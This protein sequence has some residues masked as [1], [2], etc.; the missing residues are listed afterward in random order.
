MRET[1]QLQRLMAEGSRAQAEDI[2]IESIKGV[3]V[4]SHPFEQ[5]LAGKKGGSMALANVVPSDRFFAWFAEPK[6][7]S[8][9]LTGGSDFIFYG[10]ASLSGTSSEYQ[11][12]ER[13]LKKLGVDAQWVRGFLESGV[14]SELAVILPDLFLLEGTDLTV[15]MR[16][17]QPK[18]TK[19]LLGLSGEGGPEQVFEFTHEDETSYWTVRNDLLLV[20]THVDELE[21]VLASV[22]G[23]GQSSLGQSAEFRYML[24]QLPIEE[25]TRSF[26]YFSD[27]FI[28]RLVGPQVKIA[29]LRRLQA[30]AE[31]EAAT[32]AMLL[33]HL[34]GNQGQPSLE[35]LVER[36]YM[37][38]PVLVT[39][40]Q[41]A[42]DGSASSASWGSPADMPTLLERPVTGI[43]ATEKKAYARYL[44]NYNRFWRRFF[45]PIAVRLNQHSGREMEISTFILPLIDNSIY[46]QLRE[47]LMVD[48]E[49]TGLDVPRLQPEPVAQLS[50]N[51]NKQLWETGA[52]LAQDLLVKFI[53]VPPR[54]SDYFGPDLHLALGDGDPIIVMGSGGLMGAMGILDGSGRA[55]QA[56]MIPLIGSLLTRPSV[57][58]IGLTDPEAVK[59]LLRGMHTGPARSSSVMGVGAGILYGVAGKDAWRYDLNVEGLISMRFGMEVKG[60]FLAISNQPLSYDPELAEKDTALNSGAALSLAPAVA[61]RQRPALFASASEQQRKAAMSGINVLYPLMMGG[62]DTVEQA[63]EQVKVQLGFTPVHPGKGHW[64]WQDGVLSSS[65]F[66]HSGEQNQAEYL[67]GDDLFGILRQIERVQMNMQ[68]EDDGLRA[69]VRWEL[70]E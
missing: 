1:L 9:Y 64:Q 31:M 22:A 26:F 37:L 70:R 24:T 46:Q 61:I 52:D 6:A 43:R 48:Q 20:S 53:G 66:G 4:K 41:L 5:M 59:G 51:L 42:T 28:R 13:Y 65:V 36:K 39:D 34:D 44:Q 3:E 33:Y 18:I 27:P 45:D 35:G 29:Q 63:A 57:L 67:E 62:A 16:L 50:L 10:G 30:R 60:R 11:L 68:F 25:Q 17:Q 19:T 38:A 7:L 47:M 54:V 21:H 15:V 55:G 23:D 12:K 56:L 58:M 49:S 32:A 14:V 40:M 2:S 69:Q 8:E